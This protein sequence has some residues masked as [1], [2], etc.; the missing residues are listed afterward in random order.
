MAERG[1][2][3]RGG[4]PVHGGS[5]AAVPLVLDGALTLLVQKGGEQDVTLAP[6]LPEALDAPVRAGEIVGSVEVVRDGRVV[7][8]LPVASA[9]S[10]ESRG[11][12]NALRRVLWRWR[13]RT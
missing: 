5:L 7:A 1:T 11:L 9:A 8:R 2:K 12:A 4:L 13:L 6:D 10:V 3:I